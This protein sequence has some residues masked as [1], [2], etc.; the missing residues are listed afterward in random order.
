[1]LEKLLN[2]LHRDYRN[3]VLNNGASDIEI[4]RAESKIGIE[5]PEVLRQLYR[6]ADGENGSL[7]HCP[8]RPFMFFDEFIFLS[9]ERLLRKHSEQLEFGYED[10]ES[11]KEIEILEGGV[12][13][14]PNGYIKLAY[15]NKYWIP[16]GWAGASFY[17]A[18]DMDPDTLGK[19]GQVII[20]GGMILPDVYLASPN[21]LQFIDD[22]TNFI[23]DYRLNNNEEDASYLQSIHDLYR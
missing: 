14:N 7:L 1:M 9:L 12:C 3:S 6:E 4:S 13:S 5:F 16:I 2:T 21:L 8:T 19:K 11:E 23:T 15:F 20:F 22:I 17:V 18:I 10:K